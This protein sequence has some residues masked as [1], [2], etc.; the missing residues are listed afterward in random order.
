MSKT[1]KDDN[2][3]KSRKLL[4]FFLSFAAAIALAMLGKFTWELSAFLLALPAA[5]GYVNVKN[6]EAVLQLMDK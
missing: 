2:K 5:Y 4:I 1:I 6:K 3:W